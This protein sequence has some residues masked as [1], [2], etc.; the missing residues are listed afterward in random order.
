MHLDTQTDTKMHSH[1]H[2]MALDALYNHTKL[3]LC[4]IPYP[5]LDL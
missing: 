1:I 4:T 5:E 2:T 3:E